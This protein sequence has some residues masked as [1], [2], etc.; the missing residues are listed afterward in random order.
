MLGQLSSEWSQVLVFAEHG[1]CH[2]LTA[3][4]RGFKHRLGI[5]RGRRRAKN[6]LKDALDREW[7]GGVR[8]KACQTPELTLLPNRPVALGFGCPQGRSPKHILPPCAPQGP[9]QQLPD[10]RPGSKTRN[11]YVFKTLRYEFKISKMFLVAI[12]SKDEASSSYHNMT[13]MFFFLLLP[14]RK[15]K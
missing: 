10:S 5:H 15:N 1:I 11:S 14:K 3:F 2:V 9:R 4:R 13:N 8:I 12:N 7:G 6:L